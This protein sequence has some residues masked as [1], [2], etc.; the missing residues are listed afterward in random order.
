LQKHINYDKAESILISCLRS[1]IFGEDKNTFIIQRILSGSHKTYKYVLI[2]ALLAKATNSE[3]NALALQAGA[4]VDG[5][6]DARSL[7][8]KVIVP[9]EREYLN[10]SLGGSNEPFLNKPARFTHLSNTNA[11]RD[12]NDRRTLNDLIM[13]L[14]S[15]NDNN[16]AKK[17]LTFALSILSKIANSRKNLHTVR[18]DLKADLL[19]AYSFAVKFLEKSFEGETC[20]I[21]VAAVEKQ[22]YECIKGNF[23]VI[24]HKINESGSSSKEVGDIDIYH[25]KEYYHS[26]EVKDKTF[27]VYDLQHALNKVID[28]GGKQGTFIYGPR[29]TYDEEKIK[30]KLFDYEQK[31]F[32]VL[33]LDILTYLKVMLFKTPKIDFSNF[34]QTV[35][36]IAIEINATDN[37]KK[38]IKQVQ[39]DILS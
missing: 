31:R 29:A 5:P 18:I 21:I 3:I 32:N 24:P 16:D 14:T 23:N 9:F 12:G 15:V 4:P 28:N 35:M 26:I 2:T 10:D 34:I 11:V 20:A 6:Y 39:L 1:K 7:C 37:V 27:T 13:V 8:H 30:I 36:N 19:D 33:F 38:W 22:F 25:E 17:Y